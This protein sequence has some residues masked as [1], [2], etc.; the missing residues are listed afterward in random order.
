MTIRRHIH[1]THTLDY[2]EREHDTEHTFPLPFDPQGDPEHVYIAPNGLK[3]VLAFLVPDDSPEDPFKVFDEGEFYQ[4]DRSRIHDT[5]RPDIED[6]K[7]IIRASPGRVVTVCSTGDGFATDSP[8]LTPADTRDRQGSGTSA[9][10]QYLDHADGYY[11]AP[12]D[13]TDPASYADGA[14]ET[15]SQWCNGEVYG[16]CV[17]IYTRE[18]IADDWEDPDRDSECWGF[19]GTDGYTAEELKSQFD[20]AIHGNDPSRPAKP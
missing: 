18:S 13:V 12:K 4:F 3:A 8:P 2:Y 10:E 17:W 1:T 11:I 15:Y 14:V 7:R 19:Y 6:F 9:A 16:I 20:Y 5:A